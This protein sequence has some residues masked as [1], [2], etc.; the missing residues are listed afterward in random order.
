MVRGCR[1][2]RPTGTA[3]GTTLSHRSGSAH[4]PSTIMAE[5]DG[6]QDWGRR[7]DHRFLDVYQGGAGASSGCMTTRRKR[8]PTWGDSSLMGRGLASDETTFRLFLLVRPSTI[9]GP[10]PNRA[11]QGPR[12]GCGARRNCLFP[13]PCVVAPC[14]SLIAI[15]VVLDPDSISYGQLVLTEMMFRSRGGTSRIVLNT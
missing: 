2:Q 9:Y 7:W 15:E 4:S 13:R 1:V 3:R 8:I 12:V 10:S 14:D 5:Q 6:C 11:S